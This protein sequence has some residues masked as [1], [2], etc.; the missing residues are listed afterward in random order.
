MD[1]S[2][3]VLGEVLLGPPLARQV[4]EDSVPD[5]LIQPIHG[6]ADLAARPV[7]AHQPQRGLVIQACGEQ[8]VKADHHLDHRTADHRKCVKSHH[9]NCHPTEARGDHAARVTRSRE[10][11]VPQPGGLATSFQDPEIRQ[12]RQQRHR[13]RGARSEQMRGASDGR[14]CCTFLLYSLPGFSNYTSDLW[15]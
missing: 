15:S 3:I 13:G 8:P 9:Q 10:Q 14:R 1:G 11:G 7:I 12:P 5:V 6:V 2:Q 4:I